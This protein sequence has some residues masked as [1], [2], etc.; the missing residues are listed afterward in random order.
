V[1]RNR[2]GGGADLRSYFDE[3]LSNLR[4]F[5]LEEYEMLEYL[6]S[7]NRGTFVE[8]AH[9]Y[10]AFVEHLIGYGIIVRRGDEYEFAF[11]AVWKA[12]QEK[13][14]SGIDSGLE[15]KRN[16]ISRRRNRIEEE[17]RSALYRWARRLP[18]GEWP[19]VLV[20]CLTKTRQQSLGNIGIN[21]AFSRRN[22]PL[23]FVELLCFIREA[24]E[25]ATA[26][27]TLSQIGNAIDIV[28]KGRIDAHAKELSGKQYEEL[29]SALG[30]LERVFL[31][32]D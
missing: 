16:E 29:R 20:R 6:A 23:N 28:N 30:T 31:A 12:V 26:E 4:S 11:D 8:I 14:P 9:Q 15:A 2:E 21:E 19:L 13:I 17:I 32:P 3:I 27:I 1:S 10:P 18:Q 24:D 7:G 5:Y 22:S 25:F